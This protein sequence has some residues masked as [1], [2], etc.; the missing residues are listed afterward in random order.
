MGNKSLEA[1]SGDIA[2]G[3]KFVRVA[4]KQDD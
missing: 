2:K 1:L 4:S 3:S